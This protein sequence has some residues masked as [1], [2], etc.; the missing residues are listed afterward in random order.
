MRKLNVLDSLLLEGVSIAHEAEEARA[1]AI[2]D[3][4]R[5]A[6]P[7]GKSYYSFEFGPSSLGLY[8]PTC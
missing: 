7:A 1:S 2:H 6:L 8:I 3:K 4:Y 5:E